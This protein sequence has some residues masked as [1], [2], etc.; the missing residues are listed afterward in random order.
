MFRKHKLLCR[1]KFNTLPLSLLGTIN[2]LLCLEYLYQF[3]ALPVI[4]L[5]IPNK[6]L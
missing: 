4:P 6:A 3:G 2:V 5:G 1:C